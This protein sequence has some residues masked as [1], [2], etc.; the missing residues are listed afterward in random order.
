MPA[1]FVHLRHQNQELIKRTNRIYIFWPATELGSFMDK[2]SIVLP[3]VQDKLIGHFL[4]GEPCVTH[5]S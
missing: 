4:F 5:R 1:H 2:Y 3:Q